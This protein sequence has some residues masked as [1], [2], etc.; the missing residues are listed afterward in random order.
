MCRMCWR[1]SLLTA[2]TDVTHILRC[3]DHYM[4][5]TVS[6]A[7]M[8]CLLRLKFDLEDQVLLGLHFAMLL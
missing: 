7:V 5:L 6:V 4:W 8:W 2:A 1:V 3:S